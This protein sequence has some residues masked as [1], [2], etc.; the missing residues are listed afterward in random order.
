M[1]LMSYRLV[2][3]LQAG[4]L[5]LKF[6]LTMRFG[7]LIRLD[8]NFVKDKNVYQRHSHIEDRYQT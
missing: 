7:Q 4:S 3:D 5:V 6:S 2:C 8:R 1:R